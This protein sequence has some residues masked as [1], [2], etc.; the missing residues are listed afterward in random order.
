[1]RFDN[2]YINKAADEKVFGFTN[3]IHK[4]SDY[5]TSGRQVD[6]FINK[7]KKRPKQVPSYQNLR[8][9]NTEGH[10]TAGRFFVFVFLFVP[11]L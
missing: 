2:C 7:K 6:F 8:I 10:T 5:N 3:I 4:A 1:M 9:R 11:F